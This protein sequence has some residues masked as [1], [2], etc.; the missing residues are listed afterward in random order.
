MQYSVLFW[1]WEILPDQ[2]PIM[3]KLTPLIVPVEQVLLKL[4]RKQAAHCF[5]VAIKE[6]QATT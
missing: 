3:E 5:F 2:F 1:L 6:A 4:F